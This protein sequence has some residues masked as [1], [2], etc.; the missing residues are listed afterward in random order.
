MTVLVHAPEQE[1]TV[2]GTFSCENDKTLNGILKT[3]FG[4]QGCELHCL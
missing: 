1:I 3:E 4:F 2:N